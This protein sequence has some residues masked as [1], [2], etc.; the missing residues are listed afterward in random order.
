M[1]VVFAW[2]H[3]RTAVIAALV[4]DGTFANSTVATAANPLGWR[5]PPR[6]LVGTSRIVWVPGDPGGNLGE[7]V[8]P[9]FPG[10]RAALGDGNGPARNLLGLR[11]LF[12]IDIVGAN[13]T[14]GSMS[15]EAAQYHATRALYD[16]W[17]RAMYLSGFGNLEFRSA[18]WLVDRAEGR[19]GA[20]IQVVCAMLAVIPDTIMGQ[21]PVDTDASITTTLLNRSEVQLIEAPT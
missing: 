18:R 20:T 2:E 1:A 7:V 15:N 10:P 16:A 19:Y 6:Q 14:A 5:E 12:T 13:A 4:A 8:G 3:L 21:A 17:M 11:E 9:R